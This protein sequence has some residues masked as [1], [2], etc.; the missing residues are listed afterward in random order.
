MQV[1]AHL[2]SPR[3]ELMRAELLTPYAA[4]TIAEDALRAGPGA[5]LEI[6]V[7]EDASDAEVAGVRA[8]FAWLAEQGPVVAIGRA[9]RSE[10]RRPSAAA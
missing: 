8:E 6:A 4:Q 3:G 10:S 2:V 5:R 9:Q 7:A 1:W